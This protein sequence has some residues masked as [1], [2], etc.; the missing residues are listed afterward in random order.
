MRGFKGDLGVARQ[1]VSVNA[2]EIDR[3]SLLPSDA[4]TSSRDLG[5]AKTVNNAIIDPYQR[6]KRCLGGIVTGDHL[7]RP[8]V[9]LGQD[10][11]R[12]KA[13]PY[14][15]SNRIIEMKSDMID[16]QLVQARA[17][18]KRK[19]IA[20]RCQL[21]GSSLACLVDSAKLA[22][23]DTRDWLADGWRSLETQ[24]GH[25]AHQIGAVDYAGKWEIARDWGVSSDYDPYTNYAIQGGKMAGGAALA[26]VGIYAAYKLGKLSW[27]AA[28]ALKRALWDGRSKWTK[29][30][31]AVGLTAAVAAAPSSADLIS[32]YYGL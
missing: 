22:A 21:S 9:N 14:I 10:L 23:S 16:R 29:I 19:E 25:I 1:I 28:C 26:A 5:I 18:L 20:E 12:G 6:L 11:V 27:R 13:D 24:S 15:G 8:Q 7:V 30:A 31:L 2:G 17:E 32:N 3:I 4:P